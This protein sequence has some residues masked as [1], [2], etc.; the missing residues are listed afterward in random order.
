MG[1]TP[2]ALHPLPLSVPPDRWVVHK[3]SGGV[4]NSVCAR[5]DR[6]ARN[7]NISPAPREKHRQAALKRM[8]S[9]KTAGSQ[10]DFLDERMG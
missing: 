6:M 2:D 9:R 5:P 7:P 10:R 8:A 1:S 3:G 4:Q